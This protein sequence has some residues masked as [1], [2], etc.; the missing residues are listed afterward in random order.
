M[1]ETENTKSVISLQKGFCI[2]GGV[3]PVSDRWK[4]LASV[5]TKFDN[6]SSTVVKFVLGKYATE[7]NW[8]KNRN[9]GRA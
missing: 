1:E 6:C 2:D 9:I 8:E 5:G 4:T 3:Q 7:T